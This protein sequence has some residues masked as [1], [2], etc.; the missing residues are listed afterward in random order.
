MADIGNGPSASICN[1]DNKREIHGKVTL[2]FLPYN[3]LL[4]CC[5]SIVG[6]IARV[7]SYDMVKSSM[8]DLHYGSFGRG[9]LC[10]RTF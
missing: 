9:D 1:A 2:V 7:I 5:V 10:N 8:L 3:Y 4:V 6:V